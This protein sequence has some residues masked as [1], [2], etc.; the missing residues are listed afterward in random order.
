MSG[1]ASWAQGY[2]GSTAQSGFQGGQGV[3]VS[4]GGLLPIPDVYRATA[5][6]FVGSLAPQNNVSYSYAQSSPM[7]TPVKTSQFQHQPSYP[8]PPPAKRLRQD[9]SA[10]GTDAVKSMFQSYAPPVKP[11]VMVG[12]PGATPNLPSAYYPPQF[13]SQAMYYGG[14][15]SSAPSVTAQVS[16]HGGQPAPYAGGC[17]SQ[18]GME[19][20][21]FFGSQ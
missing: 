17:G 4:Q 6:N 2:T 10:S 14:S 5:M 15:Q 13:Q 1:P 18:G 7:V 20:R 21:N 16:G 8:P 9:V 19:G 11:P 12:L 3:F